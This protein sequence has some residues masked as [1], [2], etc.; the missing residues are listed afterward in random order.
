MKGR[1][2]TGLTIISPTKNPSFGPSTSGPESFYSHTPWGSSMASPWWK[3]TDARFYAPPGQRTLEG[4]VLTWESHRWRNGMTSYTDAP[5][6]V[7]LGDGERIEAVFDPKANT[8][9]K[10]ATGQ[11]GGIVYTFNLTVQGKPATIK[12]GKRL[13]KAFQASIPPTAG[14]TKVIIAAKGEPRS[15][16]REYVVA[17]RR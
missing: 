5:R 4:S 2:D 14:P 11:M 12:G 6:E 10:D 3:R 17:V 8:D 9:L 16:A 13:L 7:E 15:L 1:T